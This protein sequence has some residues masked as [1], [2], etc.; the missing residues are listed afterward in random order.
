MRAIIRPLES[1]VT[2]SG[3]RST[4]GL[5]LRLGRIVV[6]GRAAGMVDVVPI[7]FGVVGKVVGEIG[8]FAANAGANAIVVDVARP[9]SEEVA[10][11]APLG[12]I[13]A[14]DPA[15][16]TVPAIIA[17][18]SNRRRRLCW[19]AMAVPRSGLER[20]RTDAIWPRELIGRAAEN[21]RGL[22]G[23]RQCG[24][25]CAAIPPVAPVTIAVLPV[26]S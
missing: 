22:A 4:G 20:P 17:N 5:D 2:A 7:G 23:R 24:R 8:A 9:S 3:N 25:D 10:D 26:K 14:N 6:V 21:L 19:H 11:A 1:E 18:T 16:P 15:V 12:V 13:G